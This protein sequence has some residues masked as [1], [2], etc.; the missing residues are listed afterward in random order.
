[1]S[2]EQTSQLIQLMLNSVLMVT[3]C[4]IVLTGLLM[5]HSALDN[6]LYSLNREYL[7][8]IGNTSLLTGDRRLRLRAQVR[9]LRR[10]YR[11]AHFSLL[12]VHYALFAFGFSTVVV[13]LRAFLRSDALIPWSL[14]LFVIGLVILLF[15]VG[16][17]MLDLH[18][19]GR[20]LWEEINWVLQ[21]AD[22]KML[23]SRGQGAGAAGGRLASDGRAQSVL[24]PRASSQG[25]SVRKIKRVG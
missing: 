21:W 19:S 11:L 18:Y 15:S 7:D 9:Q 4:V 16:L 6:R 23:R 2:I 10:C 8:L 1:M 14:A 22:W 17:A 20:P 3:A 25:R 13:T 12:A 24:P 5:R